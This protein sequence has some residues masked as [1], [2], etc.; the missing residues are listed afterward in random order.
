[1]AL[2]SELELPSIDFNDVDLRGERF[3]SVMRELRATSWLAAALCAA[4]L[5]A[6]AWEALTVLLVKPC[7]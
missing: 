3:H 4:A 2:A 7:A 5:L 1:M 6:I